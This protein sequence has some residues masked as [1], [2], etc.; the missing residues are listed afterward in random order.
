MKFRKKRDY[1]KSRKENSQRSI[2][3][4]GDA[5]SRNAATTKRLSERQETREREDIFVFSR[6]LSRR[7][8]NNT[9]R[10]I[11]RRCG[12][13]EFNRRIPVCVTEAG[14]R[15]IITRIIE[16][17]VTSS[18]AHFSISRHKAVHASLARCRRGK[19]TPRIDRVRARG[20]SDKSFARSLARDNFASSSTSID[21]TRET[22]RDNWPHNPRECRIF[23][24]RVVATARIADASRRR[25]FHD[26]DDDAGGRIRRNGSAHV[27]TLR[28]NTVFS[29]K[30]RTTRTP[31]R[32]LV[33]LVRG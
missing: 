4:R 7:A 8:A 20:F 6:W 12:L 9:R 19:A 18:P 16:N 14:P 31:S 5:A 22:K 3:R 11:F 17:S 21:L 29:I 23:L 28:A 25:V 33:A 27:A 1:R 24:R 13:D 10:V 32:S 30:P 26:D 15:T 2:H